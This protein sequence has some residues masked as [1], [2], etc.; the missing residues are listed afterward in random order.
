MSYSV[1]WQ[2]AGQEAVATLQQ[3]IQF[4]TTNPP[5]NERPAADYLQQRLA[6]DGISS[7]IL[8]SA[9]GRANL[10]ARL[11]GDG[12]ASPLLLLGHTDVVY[13]DPAEWTHPPFGGEIHDGYIWGRGA[14][15]MKDLVTMELM[16][17]LLIKRH[18]IPLKRDI[19]FLAV[20]DEES[21][22][23]YGAH[24]MLENH[25]DKIDAEYVINEGGR[26]IIL[27]GTECYLVST[28][29]KGYSDLRLR[30]EG[31]AGHSAMPRG[32][33]PVV[34]MSRALAAIDDYQP[35]YRVVQSVQEMVRRLRSHLPLPAGADVDE[36]AGE[37]LA[38]VFAELPD[39]IGG[40]LQFALRNVFSPTMVNAG[41]KENV[42]PNE[43]TA[44]LN[45]RTL[46]GVTREE[47]LQTIRNVVGEHVSIEVKEFHPGTE[48]PSDTSLFEAIEAVINEAT[49]DSVVA[50]YLLPATTDSRFFRNHGI[51]AYGFDPVLTPPELAQTI[52]GKD[53]RIAI[54]DLHRGTERL[55]QVV[56]RICAHE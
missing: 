2:A 37:L 13:A 48:S 14:L 38:S 18:D 6:E 27:N 55:F 15:D 29:E 22:G 5:G 41:Q 19:I 10:V 51:T 4:D 52:H 56:T 44:N 31:T 11:K 40:M 35:P 36:N 33:N 42:I 17:V 46:P 26:G 12:S 34:A 7:E 20:A 25:R 43:A 50:P 53:E 23:H 45:T 1:D 47:L 9:P 49:P 32:M 16:T 54:E 8:E 3:L 28:G 24:W 21:M 39:E 30:A